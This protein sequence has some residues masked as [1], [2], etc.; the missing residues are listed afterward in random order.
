[1]LHC[2]RCSGPLEVRPNL[3]KPIKQSPSET[4]IS[5]D[6]L[7]RVSPSVMSEPC[8]GDPVERP[9]TLPK[10]TIAPYT[11]PSLG[12]IVTCP[13]GKACPHSST[14]GNIT[15]APSPSSVYMS[16]GGVTQMSNCLQSSQQQSVIQD[17]NSRN[18]MQM[19]TMGSHI[20]LLGGPDVPGLNVSNIMSMGMGQSDESRNSPSPNQFVPAGFCLS[21]SSDGN[22][23]PPQESRNV[24]CPSVKCS[25]PSFHCQHP[26]QGFTCSSASPNSCQVQQQFYPAQQLAS[27]MFLTSTI[28]PLSAVNPAY[29]IPTLCQ[30]STPAI[31]VCSNG[32]PFF[33]PQFSR[34]MNQFHSQGSMW[35]NTPITT[36]T[37]TSAGHQ[38]CNHSTAFVAPTPRIPSPVEGPQLVTPPKV[39]SP[40]PAATLNEI[41]KE[42]RKRLEQSHWYYPKLKWDSSSDL[43][44]NASP[45]TFLV[46]DSADPRFLFS[47]SVQRSSEGPTSV[48]IHFRGGKFRLDAEESIRNLMPEFASVVDLIEYYL[49]MSSAPTADME[50][51]KQVWID[52]IGKLSS[53]ICLKR[54]LYNKVPSLAHFARLSI[55]RQKTDVN[56]LNSH[57]Q[58]QLPTK[59]V[60][61]LTEYPNIV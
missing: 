29:G 36:S 15:L 48:R 38:A 2:P 30:P 42:N 58:L 8:T 28:S 32:S 34:P 18:F 11:S 1:M 44:A 25:V 10:P 35:V 24:S 46:R 3:E 19:N 61:Y 54:P 17:V 13:A 6:P 49:S 52:N 5:V 23:S 33:L 27:P 40:V 37:G 43:L 31:V 12:P 9:K 50:K 55:N 47:L 7:G 41:I 51:K 57:E 53:P 16:G 39:A 4:V 21:Q 20:N 22:G 59:L 14:S 60:D 56:K 45:G 26:G